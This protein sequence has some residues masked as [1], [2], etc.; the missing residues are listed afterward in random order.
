MVLFNN[1]YIY[2]GIG[3]EPYFEYTPKVYLDGFIL[4]K[5]K[6]TCLSY[7]TFQGSLGINNFHI[8]INIFW[9]HNEKV[10]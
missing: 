4:K 10:N 1:K 2:L 8:V 3:V 6:R 7:N 9:R 5:S